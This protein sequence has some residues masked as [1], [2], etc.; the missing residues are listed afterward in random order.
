MDAKIST[1]D[2]KSM[3][4]KLEWQI[5]MQGDPGYVIKYSSAAMVHQMLGLPGK[6][7][8]LEANESGL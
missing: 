3:L 6:H 4:R 2:A 7:E 5:M 1:L 8:D